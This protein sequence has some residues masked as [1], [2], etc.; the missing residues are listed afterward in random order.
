MSIYRS[1]QKQLVGA[2]AVAAATVAASHATAG[3]LLVDG[4]GDFASA[5]GDAVILA[6]ET[7]T[8]VVTDTAFLPAGTTVTISVMSDGAATIGDLDDDGILSLNTPTVEP[9]VYMFE[10][11]LATTVD[12]TD[13]P[14]FSLRVFDIADD[15]ELDYTLLLTDSEG[16]TAEYTDAFTGSGS[17]TLSFFLSGFSFLDP[18]FD[19]DSV[20]SMKFT[21]NAAQG[22]DF[23]IDELVV[24]PSPTA[25]G[26][27]LLGLAA[28]AYRRRG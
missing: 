15:V 3:S 12:L 10:Y 28:M 13:L 18:D 9:A 20:E 23:R 5:T 21:I 8:Y 14:G 6:G 11:D 26:F 17:G 7:E 25:A 16:D 24:V 27:G 22:N 1:F 19:L 4:F 2:G